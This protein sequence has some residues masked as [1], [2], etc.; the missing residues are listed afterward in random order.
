MA[1]PNIPAASGAMTIGTLAR[2]TGV[3]IPT[4]RYYEDIGLLPPPSRSQSNRRLYA[5]SDAARL[6][7][8]R[9]A[10]E[11]GFELAAIRTL[12]ALQENPEQSCSE[13]DEI[14][15][16]RL[17]E[18]DEKIAR[19]TALRAELERMLGGCAH[20]QIAACRVIEVLA[21]HSLCSHHQAPP[22]P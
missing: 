16:A 10:R 13:A 14:A 17:F 12:I 6:T 7:F 8:I 19:L 5:K 18:V 22:S 9:H 15:R 2:R 20:G 11:L 4:I 3:K 1:E 21:D